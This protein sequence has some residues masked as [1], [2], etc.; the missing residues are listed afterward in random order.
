MAKVSS[1]HRACEVI[2]KKLATFL[3][4]QELN[5]VPYT[6]VERNENGDS[7]EIVLGY[8]IMRGDKP[9][10]YLSEGEKTAIAFVYFVVHLSDENFT[11]SDGIIVVDD[12]VSSFN[13][14]SLYQA[15]SFLKNA[16][17]DG[18]QVFLF[19]HSFD[20]LRLLI[21][22]RK[23]RSGVEY[24]MI[25]N[26]FPDGERSAY[27]DKMD[28]EL[29]EY[30]SEYHYLFKLLKQVRDNPDDSIERAYP[31]PNIARKMWETFLMF[32]VPN[33]KSFY[34]KMDELKSDG[35]D[36][37]KLDAI[38]KF[39]NDQSHI[40]GSGFNPALV[41]ET[42]KVVKELFEMMEAIS[43]NHF[44]ILDNATN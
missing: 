37:Q 11:V 15:F 36:E 29:Y 38:Y 4:Y 9:A 20:F 35:Y 8:N 17:K 34:L 16:V 33:S 14:N 24:Y 6:E 28:K 41:P 12:P 39:T 2:N 18:H 5:F 19:T 10:V 44:K 13:S 27:I 23:N 22:W 1:K 42:K 32:S 3:G 7:K 43:P 40:T 21:N 31:V 30:E 26:R 25:K